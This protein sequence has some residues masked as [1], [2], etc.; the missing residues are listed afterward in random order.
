MISKQSATFV[1]INP[2]DW[3]I[4]DSDMEDTSFNEEF[5]RQLAYHLERTFSNS[6]D[7]RIYPIVCEDILLPF[8]R[9]HLSRKYVNDNRKIVTDAY[10]EFVSY[11]M[12]IHFGKYSL[13]RYARGTSLLDCL[14]SSESMDWIELDME[15]RTISVWLL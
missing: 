2:S 15:K 12:T 5:C 9:W 3:M 14:P 10:I 11:E 1:Y 6:P 13:R 4:D 7:K 8:T